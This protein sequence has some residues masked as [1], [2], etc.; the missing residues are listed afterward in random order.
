MS[1]TAIFLG[2]YMFTEKTVFVLG[3]GSSMELGL[4]SGKDLTSQISLATKFY[5]EGFGRLKS[6]DQILVDFCR[7]RFK[8]EGGDHFKNITRPAWLVNEGLPLAASI[9][10]F[11]ATHIGDVE[12]VE[13]SKAAIVNNINIFGAANF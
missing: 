6:G 10:N 5:F 9:D 8:S 12:V 1:L 2:I 3:A 7:N 4:P 11:L 13:L